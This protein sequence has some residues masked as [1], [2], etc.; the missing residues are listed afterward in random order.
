MNP[1]GLVLVF[2]Q[3][4]EILSYMINVSTKTRKFSLEKSFF[5]LVVETQEFFEFV[6]QIFYWTKWN[7]TKRIED[8][9]RKFFEKDKD[10]NKL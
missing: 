10:I 9:N 3:Q 8:E 7:E 4:I 2:L 6:E 5:L 1:R